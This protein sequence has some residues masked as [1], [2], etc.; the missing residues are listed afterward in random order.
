MKTL[1]DKRTN[2][3]ITYMGSGNFG[4]SSIPTLLPE[5]Y[6]IDLFIKYA[7]DQESID[8][9]MSNYLLKNVDLIITN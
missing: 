6:E 5:T 9:D 4:S 8:V 7:K 2:E 1:V 3:F